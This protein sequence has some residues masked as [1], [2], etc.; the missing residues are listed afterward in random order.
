MINYIR[1]MH[2]LTPKIEHAYNQTTKRILIDLNRSDLQMAAKKPYKS[3]LKPLVSSMV[4]RPGFKYNAKEV[5]DIGLVEFMDSVQRIP[6][7]NNSQAL[8]SGCYS[9]MIDTT[10]ISKD[11]LNWMKDIS[12]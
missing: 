12:D 4:N 7:I 2:N 3:M 11:A 8:L 10:K 9:G 6:V 1:K 5:L